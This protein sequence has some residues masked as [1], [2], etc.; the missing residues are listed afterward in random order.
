M[1]KSIEE[2]VDYA[3]Q[4]AQR[5]ASMLYYKGLYKWFTHDEI[6][7][8]CLYGL[9]TAAANWNKYCEG[10][11]YDSDR[12]DF[13]TV[14]VR[15]RMSGAVKDLQRERDAHSRQERDIIKNNPETHG[16]TPVG[17]YT[18]TDEQWAAISISA[19]TSDNTD[20]YILA[21]GVVKALYEM[22]LRY[23]LSLAYTIFKKRSVEAQAGTY[24]LAIDGSK[25]LLLAVI[26]NLDSAKFPSPPPDRPL[27]SKL[28]A[29]QT[30][31]KCIVEF[32]NL[33]GHTDESMIDT[34]ADM[35]LSD[36]GVLADIMS[37]ATTVRSC[38][39]RS[40]ASS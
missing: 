37:K 31:K 18:A 9:A 30:W 29:E 2:L 34:L 32:Q 7:A 20:Y 3:I 19:S 21:R 10:K 4:D 22:K 12:L 5:W 14:Y 33:T 38:R 24:A 27:Q 6:D 13:F 23:S 8:E 11:G 36:P 28:S 15:R 16:I 35:I 1:S 40:L 26:D 17:E 39:P 25:L